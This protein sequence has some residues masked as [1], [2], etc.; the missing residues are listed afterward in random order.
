MWAVAQKCCWAPAK[1]PHKDSQIISL[2]CKC[3][4]S[5]SR[6]S[7]AVR[8]PPPLPCS[9]SPVLVLGGYQEHWLQTDF[10]RHSAFRTQSSCPS[11]FG[12]GIVISQDPYW[13]FT[14]GVFGVWQVARVGRTIPSWGP[15][16]TFN[17]TSLLCVRMRGLAGAGGGAPA[18]Q[19]RALGDGKGPRRSCHLQ[20][21]QR[22]PPRQDTRRSLCA[23][24]TALLGQR[25][26]GK[27]EER[28]L[29]ERQLRE[30][31]AKESRETRVERRGRTWPTAWRENGI[32]WDAPI[33]G[34]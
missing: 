13:P 18:G 29:E 30:E 21:E 7:L 23:R 16:T 20:R 19:C 28:E 14:S 3:D 32:Q 12:K 4:D 26:T 33:C 31:G 11:D 5:G 25:E 6:G 22:Q 27:R 17:K 9:P 1:G 8:P 34:K 15:N 2:Q 10:G 24:G